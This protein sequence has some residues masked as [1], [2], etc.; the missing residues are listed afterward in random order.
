VKGGWAW[1]SFTLTLAPGCGSVGKVVPAWERPGLYGAV[2]P[3]MGSPQPGDPAPSFDLATDGGGT[4]HGESLRGSWVVLHFTASWCPYCDAEVE[5][6]GAL[7][8]ELAPRGV[9][10]VLIDI[11][12]DAPRWTSYVAAHVA[13]SVIALHDGTGE[14]ARRFAPPR[15]QP[16]FGDRAQVMLDS[17]LILDPEGRIMLFLFPD[18]RHFDPTFTAVR[19]ELGRLVGRHGA[20]V[21]EVV[22]VESRVAR[23][24]SS[25]RGELVVRLRVARGY[26]VMSDRPGAPE[27]IATR[28]TVDPMAGVLWADPSY[29]APVGFEIA[30]KT[31]GTF[32]GEADVRIPFE[33]TAGGV[34]G[35]HRGTATLRYQACTATRCL[36][37]VTQRFDVEVSS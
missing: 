14:V 29:P 25:G 8:T 28:V 27:Y 3:E 11:E 13:S 10:V 4:F 2:R 12:E 26:H 36:F 31:I 6:L 19:A 32:Q 22:A 30:G 35:R 20:S 9:K 1:L 24:P 37:P 33:L 23:A 15:A 7:A 18:S 21:E 16:S 17:T 5:H 34:P